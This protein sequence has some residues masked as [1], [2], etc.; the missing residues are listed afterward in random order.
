M[1]KR[2][3]HGVYVPSIYELACGAVQN[4][5]APNVHVSLWS[6]HGAYTVVSLA[7]WRNPHR[8]IDSYRTA[9]EARRAWSR[10]VSE[11][12]KYQVG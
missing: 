12:K 4:Y 7:D 2:F 6:Q 8:K 11:V 10:A 9:T 3:S 1:R 5:N